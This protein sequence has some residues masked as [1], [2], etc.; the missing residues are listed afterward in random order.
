MLPKCLSIKIRSDISLRS[1]PNLNNFLNN[2]AWLFRLIF[3]YSIICTY[4]PWSPLHICS[5]VSVNN[6]VCGWIYHNN[7][8]VTALARLALHGDPLFAVE[9]VRCVDF[10]QNQLFI[11]K[12]T[13]TT[14]SGSIRLLLLP[15]FHPLGVNMYPYPNHGQVHEHCRRWTLHMNSWTDR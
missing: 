13:W 2:N 12:W 7:S 6:H 14:A 5:V 8:S 3:S 15:H 11:H 9:W 1:F 4:S 10:P